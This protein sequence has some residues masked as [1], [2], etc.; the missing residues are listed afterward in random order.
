M[1]NTDSKAGYRPRF[2]GAKDSPVTKK[3]DFVVPWNIPPIASYRV[4]DSEGI[5]DDESRVLHGVT[6]EQVLGWY[7]NMVFGMLVFHV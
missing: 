3:M 6:N 2:P 1:S 5:V 4:M 7:K